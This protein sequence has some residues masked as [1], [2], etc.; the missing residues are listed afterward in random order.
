MSRDARGGGSWGES[1]GQ[2]A[3]DPRRKRGDASWEG[4]E[5]RITPFPE[6]T[7]KGSYCYL[8]PSGGDLRQRRG[9]G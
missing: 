1:E 4:R 7:D 2:S 3:K 6:S 5:R 9:G 8:H